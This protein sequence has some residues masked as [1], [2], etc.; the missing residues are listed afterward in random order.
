MSWVKVRWRA[1]IVVWTSHWSNIMRVVNPSWASHVRFLILNCF[2]LGISSTSYT[3]MACISFK[4][5]GTCLWL[6]MMSLI[7]VDLMTHSSSEIRCHILLSSAS[8]HWRG[9]LIDLIN[10]FQID[11]AAAPV[12]TATLSSLNQR[13]SNL[14]EVKIVVEWTIVPAHT[15]RIFYLASMT[16]KRLKRSIY[17]FFSR[18][19]WN[20]HWRKFLY[21]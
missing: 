6:D 5:W 8:N 4:S 14:W 11:K 10:G 17:S 16:L 20:L 9:V 13:W 7:E 1:V 21:T 2:T 15:N 12:Y 18:L 3:W 19:L